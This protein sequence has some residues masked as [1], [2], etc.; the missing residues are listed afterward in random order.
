MRFMHFAD[1]HLD[2]PFV[3]LTKSYPRLQ[4]S[5][6]NAPFKAFKDG[7]SIAIKEAVDVV[8]IVG[9]IY[10]ASKQT[11]YAQHF[12]MQQLKRL[13]GAEIPVVICHGNHDYLAEDRI[14]LNYP[15]NVYLF[16]DEEV[17]YVDLTLSDQTTCRFYGFSYTQRW[18]NERKIQ[19]FPINPQ[20]TTYTIGLYHGSQEGLDQEAGH[21]APFSIQEMLAKH[22]DYWALGHIHQDLELNHYPLIR[23]AGTIQGRNRLELGPKG[24]YLVEMTSNQIDSHFISLAPIIWQE[25]IIDCQTDW[26]AHDLVE[27]IQDLLD[28]F[29]SEAQQ[30]HYSIMLTL[31]LKNAQRLDQTLQDQIEKRELDTVLP[32]PDPADYFVALIRIQL[33]RQMVLQAFEYDQTLKQ[34]FKEAMVKL[35]QEETYQTI[36]AD[37]FNHDK[38]RQWL[39]DLGEDADMKAGLIDQAQ[40]LMVQA[41]GFDY[42]ESDE[43]ED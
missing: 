41:I 24:A 25:A 10:D 7:V 42:K 28:N 32:E 4:E 21:Y 36:L 35:S 5:L 20:Q 17:D 40:D 29:Q 2:S 13:A 11:I 39:P 19:A 6:V 14:I 8:V 3:G 9:D 34:S 15:D 12:F 33:D 43:N 23:Y 27:E 16:K 30:G 18:I 22:Y 1:L 26:Q 38:V 31:R 37:F